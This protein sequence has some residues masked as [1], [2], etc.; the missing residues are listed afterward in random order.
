[1]DVPLAQTH[2]LRNTINTGKRFS[3]EILEKYDVPIVA[4]AL[5]LYLLELPGM[6][7]VLLSKSKLT[8]TRFP[9]LLTRV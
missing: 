5:K 3:D 1:M 4:S 7:S 8:C 6:S 9:R 2:N